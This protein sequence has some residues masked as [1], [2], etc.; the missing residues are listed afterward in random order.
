MAGAETGSTR[1]FVMND[2]PLRHKGKVAAFQRVRTGDEMRA[3]IHSSG[4]TAPVN[5]TEPHWRIAE[6]VRPRLVADGMFLAG[7]TIADD[8]LI[9]ID[10]FSPG[11][12]G[13]L[14]ASPR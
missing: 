3:N 4:S 11:A 14:R 1:I 13:S 2:E 8:K 6:A 10:V 5:L 12:S 7:L 9:D